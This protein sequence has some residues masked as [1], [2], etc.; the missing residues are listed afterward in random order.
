MRRQKKMAIL[1][2]ELAIIPISR[3]KDIFSFGFAYFS[4]EM[5]S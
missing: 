1:H 4:M 2:I 3:K 5:K